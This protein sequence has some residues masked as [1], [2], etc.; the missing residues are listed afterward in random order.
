MEILKESAKQ[1]ML[2][3]DDEDDFYFFSMAI[4]EV[5]Y[6]VVLKRA[7]DGELLLELLNQEVPDVLFMDMYLPKKN[8][9]ECLKEIRSNKKYDTLP[10]I[11]YTS[12]KELEQI[13]FCYREG[14]NLYVLKPTSFNELKEIIEKILSIEWKKMMYYPTLPDFV[15]NQA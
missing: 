1:V 9:R 13:E 8:G 10:I 5:P 6:T 3:E 12:M 2:A 14:S 4:N 11:I 7:D 15:L